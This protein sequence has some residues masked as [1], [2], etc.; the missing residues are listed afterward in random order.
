MVY[1]SSC[2]SCPSLLH[3]P[4]CRPVSHEK[5]MKHKKGTGAHRCFLTFR[6]YLRFLLFTSSDLF[7]AEGPDQSLRNSTY[8]HPRSSVSI[9]GSTTF[10]APVPLPTQQTEHRDSDPA[11]H[12]PD[13]SANRLSLPRWN[14]P[15]KRGN[16]LLSTRSETGEPSG[17]RNGGRG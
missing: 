13:H 11:G 16:V 17:D 5:R 15:A 4:I 8:L 2:S 7:S 10:T 9:R 1:L 6:R 12:H 3:S 14:R